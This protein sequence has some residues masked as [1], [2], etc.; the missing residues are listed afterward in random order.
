[1]EAKEEPSPMI[2]LALG[3]YRIVG[4]LAVL[5][6]L[7]VGNLRAAAPSCQERVL[8]VTVKDGDGKL[9]EGLAARDFRAEVRGS[10]VSILSAEINSSPQRIVLLLDISESMSR[11]GGIRRLARAGVAHLIGHLGNRAD[12]ALI[13]F[14]DK[15]ELK[16]SLGEGKEAVLEQ[17]EFRP[18]IEPNNTAL[19][20]S[21]ALGATT[22][23]SPQPED[24]IYLISDGQDT[25]SKASW[26][27][28]EQ[29]LLER[30]I[31]LFV[32]HIREIG[33]PHRDEGRLGW[34]K[35]RHLVQVSGGD[36]VGYR[37]HPRNPELTAEKESD[38][39]RSLSS[40]ALRSG[41]R[42]SSKSLRNGN[43]K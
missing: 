20:D 9:V 26:D 7:L 8:P 43:W 36:I 5:L 38:L 40:N 29:A 3:C 13:V 18:D 19:F 17:L 4:A 10:P 24:V 33:V 30:G 16:I 25:R 15:A 32:F 22:L 39:L 14:S 34:A 28:V 21:I 23:D 2:G 12:Y 31:R 27:D 35:L 41:P 42:L 37:Y 6:L 1:M 11:H